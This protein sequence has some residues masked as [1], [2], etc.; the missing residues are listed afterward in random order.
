MVPTSVIITVVSPMEGVPQMVRAIYLDMDGT[1]ADLFGVPNWLHYLRELED[2]YP[3]EVAEPMHDMM[4]LDDMLRLLEDCGV[5]VGVVS[6]G[7]KDCSPAYLKA[8]RQAKRE[9][10]HRHLPSVREAHVVPY[11]EPKQHS[12][13]VKRDAVLVDDNASV[14]AKWDDEGA[15]RTSIDPSEL[16][17]YVAALA[18]ELVKERNK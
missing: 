14:R 11:G 7:S 18:C 5:T 15:G 10:L 3:Y 9:W 16:I 8:V 17:G 2:T 12:A 1:I 6:W 13:R 4:L